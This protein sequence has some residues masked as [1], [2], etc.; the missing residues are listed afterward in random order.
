VATGW[1]VWGA[2]LCFVLL[3]NSVYDIDGVSCVALE[4]CLCCFSRFVRSQGCT[5]VPLVGNY[6]DEHSHGGGADVL[7]V[8]NWCESFS[9]DQ[10]ANVGLSRRTRNF[11]LTNSL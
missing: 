1:L 5:V 7:S 11:S 2:A 8:S 10:F 4:L 6:D 3:I 9:P